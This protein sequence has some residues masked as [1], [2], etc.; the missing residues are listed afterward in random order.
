MVERK[1][2]RRPAARPQGLGSAL[3]QLE[4]R[5]TTFAPLQFRIHAPS[6]IFR[7]Y[8]FYMVI[9]VL[10]IN[11]DQIIRHVQIDLT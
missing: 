2:K 8:F 7:P 4:P 5:A 1:T 6:L 10:F 9:R 3:L 11:K